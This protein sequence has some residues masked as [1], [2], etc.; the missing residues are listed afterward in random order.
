MRRLPAGLSDDLQAQSMTG[1]R[2]AASRRLFGARERKI[3]AAKEAIVS[4]H[5][6]ME[7]VL[8]EEAGTRG[9]M[10]VLGYVPAE[11]PAA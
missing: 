4:G 9:P 8:E 7:R 6:P 5:R 1:A 10:K 3:D 11:R 2:V